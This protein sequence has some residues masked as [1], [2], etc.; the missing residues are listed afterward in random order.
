MYA[1]VV[2]EPI[3]THTILYHRRN[4]T[5]YFVL[6]K[7]SLAPFLPSVK[8]NNNI[9]FFNKICFLQKSYRCYQVIVRFFHSLVFYVLSCIILIEDISKQTFS[10]SF[11]FLG[12]F[13]CAFH[14]HQYSANIPNLKTNDEDKCWLV[15]HQFNIILS[16][17]LRHRYYKILV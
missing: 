17:Y 9:Y 14:S 5:K 6:H 16:L 4:A 8:K 15:A 10:H 11:C 2:I 3:C 7:T 12:T 1:E 13:N